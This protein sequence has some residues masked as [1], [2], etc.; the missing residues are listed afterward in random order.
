MEFRQFVIGETYQYYVLI[1]GFRQF[2]ID[3]ANQITRCVSLFVN[4]N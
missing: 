3:E 4:C 2:V 1:L